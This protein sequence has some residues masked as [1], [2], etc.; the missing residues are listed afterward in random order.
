MATD[1]DPRSVERSIEALLA[2]VPLDDLP[3]TGWVLRGVERPESVAGHVLGVAHT[4]LALAP[5]VEP[6]LDLGRTLA[7]C[8]VHDA[9]EARSGDLPRPAARHLPDG[10]KRAMEDALAG[11]VV[12][13]LSP[14]AAEA[15]A[16]YRAGESREARFVHACDRIQLGVRLVA[17]ERAGR[18]G[19]DEF[20]DALD[21]DEVREFAPCAAALE[22]LV[23]RRSEAR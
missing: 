22:C 16:E 9:P 8:L 2:L 18:R 14:A 21:S 15:W 1:P 13:P 11:E 19:L 20:W 6:P 7:M 3:R 4:A 23:E 17:Y 5:R 12:E 10:A